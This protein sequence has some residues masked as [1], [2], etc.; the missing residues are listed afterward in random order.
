MLDPRPRPSVCLFACLAGGLA[1]SLAC[2][3]KCLVS[4][5]YR[6]SCGDRYGEVWFGHSEQAHC[7]M[8]GPDFKWCRAM[9]FRPGKYKVDESI[10]VLS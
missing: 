10:Q 8:E 7:L 5:V 1:L 2:C 6:V 3:V 9:T 4:A